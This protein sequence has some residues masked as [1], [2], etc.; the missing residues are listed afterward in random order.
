MPR[1]GLINIIW[2]LHQRNQPLKWFAKFKLGEICIKGDARSGSPK[3]AVSDENIKN[4]Q[5][6]IL[7][8]C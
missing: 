3:E 5:K 4:G 7:I 6:I 8:D 2:T 1:F